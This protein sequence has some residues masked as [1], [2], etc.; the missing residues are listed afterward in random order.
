MRLRT[1]SGFE[2]LVVVTGVGC[3][4]GAIAARF[5]PWAFAVLTGWDAAAAA[6][7]GSVWLTVGHFTPDQTRDLATR[8]DNSR[9]ATSLIL[10]TSSTAS[11]VGAGLAVAPSSG[12]R[13]GERTAIMV[14]SAI[15]VLLSW[16]VVHTVFALRYAHEYYTPPV[17]GIDFGNGGEDPDYQDF[18]YFAFT[19]GMTFQTSDAVIQTRRIRRT[20]LRHALLAYLFGAVILAVVVNVIAS[21]IR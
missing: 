8:E 6:L 21:L 18:A 13:A 1:A 3:L 2:R 11:L 17:G 10:V 14:I 5:A 19:F 20:A 12:D 4:A 9:V 16:G 15:T 7:V